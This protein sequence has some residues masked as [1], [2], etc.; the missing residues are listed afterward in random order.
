MRFRVVRVCGQD[1][2]SVCKT[3]KHGH[4]MCDKSS[5]RFCFQLQIFTSVFF[6]VH[7]NQAVGQNLHHYTIFNDNSFNLVYI[8]SPDTRHFACMAA[9]ILIPFDSRKVLNYTKYSI[10]CIVHYASERESKKKNRRKK[11][12]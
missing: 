8:L 5:S 7:E 10:Y 9:K 6:V 3:Q 4:L 11:M 2:W 1:W 12:K